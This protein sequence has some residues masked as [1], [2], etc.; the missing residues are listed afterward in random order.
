MTSK[1]SFPSPTLL[2]L[3]FARYWKYEIM[4]KDQVVGSAKQVKGAVEESVGRAVGD[5]KLESERRADKAEG[6]IQKAI[7]DLRNWLKWK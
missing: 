6:K 2:V 4:D 7:G 3:S 5:A 1:R